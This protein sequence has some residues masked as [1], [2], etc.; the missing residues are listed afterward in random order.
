LGKENELMN[1]LWIVTDEENPEVLEGFS[2]RDQALEYIATNNGDK[3]T[4]VLR[5]LLIKE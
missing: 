5:T 4:L 2:S 3:D 1:L